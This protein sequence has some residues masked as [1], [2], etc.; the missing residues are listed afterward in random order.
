MG[1]TIS[2]NP[3]LNL[4]TV[5]GTSAR[6]A[7]MLSSGNTSARLT[8]SDQVDLSEGSWLALKDNSST[9]IDSVTLVQIQ[10]ANLELI[11]AKITDLQALSAS[12]ETADGSSSNW[13]ALNSSLNRLESELSQLIGLS[14]LRATA[15]VS[16]S[17]SDGAS[18]TTNLDFAEPIEIINPDGSSTTIASVEI[19]RDDFLNGFH[20]ADGC[21]ICKADMA[22]L[23]AV[24]SVEPEFD[25]TATTN[26]SNGSASTGAI[27]ASGVAHIDPL[28]KLRAWDFNEGESLSYSFYLGDD[29][30]PYTASYA[31]PYEQHSFEIPDAQ[32]AELRA[33]Y[34]T[35]SSYAPFE[36]EEVT[37]S[38]AGLVV[39]DLRNAYISRYD[40]DDLAGTA[41]FAYY[42]YT[43]SVGGDTWYVDPNEV[44]TN[45]TFAEDTYGRMT[46][47]HEIGHSIG[48]K[49][50]FDG[51]S[52][53]NETLTGNGLV[54]TMRESVM[55]YTRTNY[56]TYYESSG[57]VTSKNIYSNT[58]M[59]YDIAAVEYLYGAITDANLGDTTYTFGDL[60]HQRIQTLV[61]SGGTDTIDL[62]NARH[63][64]IIDLTPGSLSSI[65]YATESEQEEY[66]NTQGYS[67]AA[68]Q[69][70]I[71]PTQLFQGNDNVGI[72]FSATIENVIG[73]SGNDDITGNS[74]DNVFTGGY[75]NDT[76]D[77]GDGSDTAIYSGFY[78]Q[79]SIVDNNDGTHTVT[80]TTSDRDGVDTVQ[81]IETLRFSDRTYTLAGDNAGSVV[82]NSGFTEILTLGSSK[83]N[84]GG[85]Y[86]RSAIAGNMARL[87]GFGNILASPHG[88][89][90]LAQLMASPEKNTAVTAA[91][92]SAKISFDRLSQSVNQAQTQSLSQQLDLISSNAQNAA[93]INSM[94]NIRSAF[95]NVSPDLVNN[96]LS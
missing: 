88:F 32:K 62:T 36:F 56:V 13:E 55:S 85:S 57:S 5:A 58:P 78:A 82:I 2:G 87:S 49:H 18:V 47:L 77:G 9:N 39:G 81:N 28:L 38:A 24:S 69:S 35:W 93:A 68:V 14:S 66:W 63:R 27:V 43:S 37:E 12:L 59:I 46:A 11:S 65:G 7:E 94:T 76:L 72:A 8:L 30:V 53:T 19:S 44:S 23:G 34:D 79:Y 92:G 41:A 22:A 10:E 86:L 89:S 96:L 95:R 60:D 74:A 73:S 61:D 4:L 17:S 51:A 29:V 90:G 83:L 3:A 42:P 6:G 54:D 84:S 75:G 48:L 67:L 40:N 31:E 64:S 25:E 1:N 20:F 80:D 71:T 52:G 91:L 15:T 50:P 70:I 26:S 16:I 21:P 45:A 33:A